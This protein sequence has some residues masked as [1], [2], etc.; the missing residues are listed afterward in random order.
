MKK[1]LFILIMISVCFPAV[2]WP[3][4]GKEKAERERMR[5]ERQWQKLEQETSSKSSDAVKGITK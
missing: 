3:R 5:S 1:I 4:N 2:G